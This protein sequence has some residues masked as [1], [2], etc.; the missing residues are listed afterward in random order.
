M[1]LR[2][3]ES[4]GGFVSLD[5]ILF[6]KQISAPVPREFNVLSWLVR[7]ISPAPTQGIIP[8]WLAP[9]DADRIAFHKAE[10]DHIKG[11]IA[12]LVKLTSAHIQYALVTS[13]ALFAWILTS[14]SSG[15]D[16][17]KLASIA[18]ENL[19]ILVSLPAAIA[20]VFGLFSFGAY[21]RIGQKGRYL[22]RIE[23]QLGVRSLGW[24]R[25]FSS[26]AP[27]LGALHWLAWMLLIIGDALL[28]YWL[29]ESFRPVSPTY[30]V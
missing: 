12:E 27:L 26:N 11:E 13:G 18:A 9:T 20:S 15:S 24:E 5:I 4:R 17:G 30:T 8:E 23:A 21:L 3:G 19:L 7:C 10:F 14:V 2:L 1:E 28:G 6:A 22:R 16:K 29:Y 25:T